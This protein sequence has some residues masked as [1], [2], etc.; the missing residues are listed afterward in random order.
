MA[1]RIRSTFEWALAIL[2]TL[3]SIWVVILFTQSQ[4]ESFGY[5][6][7]DLLPFPMLYFLEVVAV[8]LLVLFAQWRMMHTPGGAWSAL[9]WIGAGIL[10]AFVILGA[11]TIGPYLIPS[12]LSFLILGIIGDIQRKRNSLAHFGGFILSAILQSALFFLILILQ[13]S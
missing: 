5:Q 7:R 10:L 8:S 12:M 9:P 3:F 4:L 11:L 1:N 13:A 2:G 6:W